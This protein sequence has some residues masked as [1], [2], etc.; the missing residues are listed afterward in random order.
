MIFKNWI[1][2]TSPRTRVRLTEARSA[3]PPINELT[4]LVSPVY[5]GHAAQSSARQG[6]LIEDTELKMRYATKKP[7]GHLL[8]TWG[9]SVEKR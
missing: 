9:G 3:L 4:T 7:Y 2:R 5:S 8:W 1:R 6:R